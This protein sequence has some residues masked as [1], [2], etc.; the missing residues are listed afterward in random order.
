METLEIKYPNG[1]MVINV[2]EFFPCLVK[3]S[4]KL[5]PLIK[6]YCSPQERSELG[7]YLSFLVVYWEG[8]DEIKHRRALSNY[9]LYCQMEVDDEWMK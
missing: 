2:H 3:H 9:K 7:R 5:F 4:R 8:R 1:R 6:Q